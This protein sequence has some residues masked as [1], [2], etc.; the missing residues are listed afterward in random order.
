MADESCSKC[1]HREWCD[2]LTEGV[3]CKHYF[4]EERVLENEKTKGSNKAEETELKYNKPKLLPCPFCGGIA[5]YDIIKEVD[6]FPGG[7]GEGY[8]KEVHRLFCVECTKCGARTSPCLYD[9]V[10]MGAPFMFP[11]RYKKSFEGAAKR[12]NGRNK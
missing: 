2:W 8:Y 9:A 6:E 5:D 4:P 12:W 7:H 3:V 1:K 11:G 10:D